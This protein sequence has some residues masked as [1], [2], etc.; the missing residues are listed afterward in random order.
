MIYDRR[1]TIPVKKKG[2]YF[3]NVPENKCI[4]FYPTFL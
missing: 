4:F 3:I 2:I 1:I